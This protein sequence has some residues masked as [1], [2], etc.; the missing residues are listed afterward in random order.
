MSKKIVILNGSP[1]P[2]GNT[3]GLI[4]AFTKGAEEAG[5][6]VQTFMLDSMNIQGCKGCMCGQ[7]KKA[8]PCS[9]KDDMDLIYAAVRDADTI[10]WASPLYWWTISA[11]LRAAVDRLYALVE[12]GGNGL[13]GKES[14]LLMAAAGNDFDSVAEYYDYIMDKIQ[15]KN[16]GKVLASGCALVG[17][18]DNKPEAKKFLDEA[19]NLGVS[20]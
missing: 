13:Y 1:R 18:I 5:H 16:L 9:Q 7:G 15:W 11:Q 19:Y 4:K 14:L 10:V 3:A 6:S 17:D 2:E 12:G 20:L 8:S